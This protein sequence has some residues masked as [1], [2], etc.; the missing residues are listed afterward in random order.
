MNN[1]SFKNWYLSSNGCSIIVDYKNKNL[2]VLDV[3]LEPR[4]ELILSKSIDSPFNILDLIKDDHQIGDF[5]YQ[6]LENTDTGK[7]YLWRRQIEMKL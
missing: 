2:Q 5:L 4:A 3:D 7:S 6:I 1:I